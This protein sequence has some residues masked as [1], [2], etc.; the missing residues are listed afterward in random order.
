M[1][2]PKPTYFTTGKYETR[3][4]LRS[5]IHRRRTFENMDWRQI[6]RECGVSD[7]TAKRC[8]EEETALRKE[9]RRVAYETAGRSGLT[10]SHPN[11]SLKPLG[12]AASKPTSGLQPAAL[13]FV[14]LII[15]AMIG[16]LAAHI[17]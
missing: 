10:R 6:G 7:R 12:M 16:G 8:H 1:A 14:M 11:T 17:R 4:Q 13:I 3:D 5:A 2:N 15:A 9:A